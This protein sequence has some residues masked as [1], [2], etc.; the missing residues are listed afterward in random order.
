MAFV[1]LGA[2]VGLLASPAS[3]SAFGRK[4]AA[5]DDCA[6]CAAPA[7]CGAA[8]C[9]PAYTVSYV[10]Q[11][12]TAYKTEN[13]T[14]DVKV[15]EYTQVASKE[16]YKYLVC[17]P[18]AKKQKVTVYETRTKEEGFKYT[19]NELVAVKDKVKVCEYT[20]VTKDVPYVTYE[21]V[22]VVTKQQRTVYDTVCV[23]VTVTKVVEPPK[24][25]LFARCCKKPDP[26]APP[27]CPQVVTCTV[28]QKQCVARVVTVDV[29]TFTRVEKK[30]VQKVTQTVPVW[31]ERE[32]TVQKCVPVEKAGT[33][34]VCFTV[35]VEKE[36]DVQVM[37]QVEKTDTRTVY[38]TVPVEKVV[39]QT[40][41]R[42]VPYET[43]VK[44]AV[45]TPVPAPA[46]APCA[47]P[48]ETPCAA[49]CAPA[50][51]APAPKRGCCRK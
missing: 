46:P 18:V 33:R 2:A 4:K 8:P 27:P 44:V 48:C 31:T 42:V 38:K 26:C 34:T 9:A 43:T 45:R 28:M 25:G 29:T 32:V 35:P 19:V 7:P 17:V 21:C 1:V 15:V 11:K 6:P 10:D 22:P 23:P 5:A 13:Y 40:L 39:K 16:D 47:A 51:C 37:T 49:P 36:I 20:T 12:V 3:V 24:P 41:C 14:Q 50:P 30:G